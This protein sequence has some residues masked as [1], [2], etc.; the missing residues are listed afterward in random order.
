LSVDEWLQAAFTPKAER[1]QAAVQWLGEF[2]KLCDQSPNSD[3]TKVND[4]TKKEVW[5]KYLKE[6]TELEPDASLVD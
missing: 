5:E 4:D 2:F 6:M 3:F 1:R